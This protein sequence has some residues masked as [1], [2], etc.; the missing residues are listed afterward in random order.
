LQ[1]GA[2][3]AL[4]TAGPVPDASTTPEFMDLP[5][6]DYYIVIEDSKGC[7]FEFGPITV[8]PCTTCEDFFI[9]IYGCGMPI[10]SF[11]VEG[12]YPG[13]I[14]DTLPEVFVYCEGDLGCLDVVP[15]GGTA[16]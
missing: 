8:A 6:G 14:L 5:G 7:T 11:I 10:D 13:G 4:F 15:T 3:D 2:T 12:N 16:L 9:D 1:P